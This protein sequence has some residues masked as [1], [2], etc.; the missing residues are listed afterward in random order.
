M[1]VFGPTSVLLLH[2]ADHLYRLESIIKFILLSSFLSTS[3]QI[4]M[5]IK[6]LKPLEND[7]TIQF[8]VLLSRI[9]DTFC[10]W[11]SNPRSCDVSAKSV[12]NRDKFLELL[13]II[14]INPDAETSYLQKIFQ[15]LDRDTSLLD[16]A[17][18]NYKKVN[19]ASTALF[20]FLLNETTE[21]HQA[22]FQLGMSRQYRQAALQFWA[23]HSWVLG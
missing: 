3:D 15:A 19:R 2:F 22:R 9:I 5:M 12:A 17:L 18:K 11:L 1:T 23:F 16:E 8:S 10:E 21:Y 14:M 4:T 7:K 6:K 13:K 20:D